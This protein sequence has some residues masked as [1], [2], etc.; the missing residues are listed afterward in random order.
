RHLRARLPDYMIPASFVWLD[1]LPLTPHGKLNHR[2]LPTPDPEHAE[3]PSVYAPPETPLH[4]QIVDVWKTVLGV[5]NFGIDA[6]FFNIGG[7]SLLATQVV[8]RL[9]DVL[10]TDIPLRLMFEQPTARGFADAV[11]ELRQKGRSRAIPRVLPVRHPDAVADIDQLTDADV[12]LLLENLLA[13]NP[14]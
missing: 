10:D 12:E 6:N 8:S 7:H 14:G 4:Q 3:D 9:G 1:A 5:D 11:T 13:K 2:A